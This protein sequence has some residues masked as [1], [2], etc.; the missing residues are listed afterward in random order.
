MT[1][2]AIWGILSSLATLT[3]LVVQ[4]FLAATSAAAAQQKAYN[5]SQANFEMLCSQAM[6]KMRLQAA[7]DSAQAQSVEPSVDQSETD[8]KNEP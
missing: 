1:V 8:R 5:L 6:T 2:A 3:V 4:Q 7:Q